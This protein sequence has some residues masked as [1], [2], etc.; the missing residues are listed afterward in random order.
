MDKIFT[1]DN[2]IVIENGKIKL[3]YIQPSSYT[4]AFLPDTQSYVNYKPAIMV[5]QI[6]WLIN[7]K[8]DLNLQFVAHEGDIVQNHDENPLI[9]TGSTFTLTGYTEWSF[10]QW[11]MNRLID[12]EIPYSTL[13]GNHDYKDGT[14]DNTML[15]S[16][17]PLSSFTGMTTYQG[18][19]DIDSDNTYHIVN[20]DNNKVLILSLEFGPRQSVLDWADTIV[21]SNSAIPHRDLAVPQLALEGAVAVNLEGMEEDL[22]VGR[23]DHEI[24]IFPVHGLV[25]EPSDRSTGAEELLG[26]IPGQD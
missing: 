18:S 23:F 17:F 16:Y 25:L 8:N 10:M 1:I 3:E 7:N 5:D 13:P 12:S 21:K 26:L 15:N 19:Y 11:Q 4:I 6:D 24:L 22:A 20:V 9:S 2:K 14:R